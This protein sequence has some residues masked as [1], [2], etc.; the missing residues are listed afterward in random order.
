MLRQ[1]CDQHNVLLIADEVMS[2]WFRTG[3]AFAIEHWGVTPDFITT[4]KGASAAYTPVAVTATTD[5]VASF[6][7][8]EVFCHGHTYA[9]HPLAA[10]AIPAAISELKKVMASGLPQRV[11]THLKQKLFELAD[12]HIS[13]GDVRGIGHFWGLEL[14]KNR[15]TKEPFDTKAD[16]FSTK[17]LMTGRVAGDAMQQGVYIS[18][19]YDT[20]V[21]APPLIITEAQVDEALAVLDKSLEIADREAVDTGTPVSHSTDYKGANG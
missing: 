12:K 20:L 10:A 21:I 3:T 13:V 18:P 6:F 16:K 15:Q 14:V 7:E 9:F 2:A 1:I 5:R 11:S 8:N 4:A 17:T 19:W